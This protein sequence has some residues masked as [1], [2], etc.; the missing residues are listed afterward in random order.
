MGQ[1]R[2][3]AATMA[4]ADRGPKKPAPVRKPARALKAANGG[5]FAFDMHDG[6]DDRDADFQR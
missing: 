3:K 5:G 1:L 4:A 6:E 2:A